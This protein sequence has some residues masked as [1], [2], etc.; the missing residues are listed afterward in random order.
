MSFEVLLKIF[1]DN[2]SNCAIGRVLVYT[3]QYLTKLITFFVWF[4][5]CLLR[6]LICEKMSYKPTLLF[7]IKL[8]LDIKTDHTR[9][10]LFS[11]LFILKFSLSYPKMIFN[12][13]FVC[14]C[15]IT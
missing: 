4:L 7:D 3:V 15:L 14:F 9:I 1:F 11:F 6:T 8:I 2:L 13:M 10:F 12:S 5:L